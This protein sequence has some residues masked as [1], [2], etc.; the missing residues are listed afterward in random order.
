MEDNTEQDMATLN[1]GKNASRARATSAVSNDSRIKALTQELL[2]KT[3]S[4]RAFL[5]GT[6]YSVVQAMNWGLE[7]RRRKTRNRN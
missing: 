2:D 3:V 7:G 4:I 1:A 6:S 5:K